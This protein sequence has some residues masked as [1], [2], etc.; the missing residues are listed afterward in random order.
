MGA[1]I[2]GRWFATL[3][4]F[5]SIFIAVVGSAAIALIVNAIIGGPVAWYS[6]LGILVVVALLLLGLLLVDLIVCLLSPSTPIPPAPPLPGALTAEVDCATAQQWLA[7]AQA[8]ARQL[9]A[10]LDAQVS[11]IMAAQQAMNMARVGLAAASAGL[12]ATFFGPV[13]YSSGGGRV[14]GRDNCDVANREES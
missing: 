5:I 14:H 7:D 8:K 9:Q 4:Y 2:L 12:A 10:E 1:C 3:R 13:G 11:R 6:Y